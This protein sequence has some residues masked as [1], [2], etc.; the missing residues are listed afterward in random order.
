MRSVTEGFEQRMTRRIYVV[1]V[2]LLV[3]EK[4]LDE[5][6]DKARADLRNALMGLPPS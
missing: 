3:A 2:C 4:I 5:K 6:M 1:A